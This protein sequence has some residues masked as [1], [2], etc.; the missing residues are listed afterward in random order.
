MRTNNN[1]LKDICLKTGLIALLCMAFLVRASAQVNI[2]TSIFPPYSPYYADYSGSNA[3]KVLIILQNTSSRIVKLNLK[4]SITGNNGV[5]IHTRANYVPLVP[6]TLNPHEV[7][8]L[9]GTSLK[10]VFDGSYLSVKG[11]DKGKL[12]QSSRLPEGMYQ[13]CIQAVDNADNKTLL[14]GASAGNCALLNIV[15]PDPPVLLG[16]FKTV[17]AT[18]PQAVVFNWAA[19]GAPMGTQYNIQMAEMPDINADPNHVLNATSFPML[20]QNVSGTAYLYNVLN[21]HLLAGKKYAWRVTA[22]DPMGKTV[23]KNNGVSPAS[24]FVYGGIAEDPFA[25]KIKPNDDLN[26]LTITTPDCSDARPT[27][28]LGDHSQLKI[29]WLWREQL[30]SI[31]HFGSLDTILTS[32]YTQMATA[33]GMVTIG[34][35]QLDLVRVTNNTNSKYAFSKVTYSTIAPV[36][37]FAMIAFTALAQNFVY[38]EKYTVKVTAF[39][40]DGNILGSATSCPWLLLEEKKEP[41]PPLKI[42]G[43]LTY[44][45]DKTLYHGANNTNITLQFADS[46]T[47]S[48]IDPAKPSVTI[49]T[50]PDGSFKTQMVQMPEDAAKK[51]M[52]VYINSPYYQQLDKN[53][54]INKVPTIEYTTANNQVTTTQDT[55]RLG[56]IRT[57]AYTNNLTVNIKKGFPKQLN[58]A[59][60]FSIFG[61]NPPPGKSLT[62]D[63]SSIDTMSHVPD[64]TQVILYRKQKASDIPLYEGTGTEPVKKT[65]FLGIMK[66]AD[67]YTQ[68]GATGQSIAVFKNLLCNFEQDD[69]YYIRVILPNDPAT[70]AQELTAP[71]KYYAYK[72]DT[73]YYA[74]PYTT[75]TLYNIIS[76][77][78]PMSHV[79]GKVMYQ[80]PSTPGVLH[81]YAG[82]DVTVSLQVSTN[83]GG[84]KVLD[85]CQ[86]TGAKYTINTT[87]YYGV[88]VTKDWDINQQYGNTVVGHGVTDAAGNFDIAVFTTDKM[89]AIDGVQVASVGDPCPPPPNKQKD[90]QIAKTKFDLDAANKLKDALKDPGGQVENGQDK[91]IFELNAAQDKLDFSGGL[92]GGS[93]ANKFYINDLLN[94]FKVVT[95]STDVGDAGAALQVF[96]GPSPVADEAPAPAPADDSFVERYFSLGG[97]PAVVSSGGGANNSAYHFVVQAFQTMDLGIIVTEVPELKDYPIHVS[98]KGK[99][100]K[101]SKLMLINAKV[102]VYR[103]PNAKKLKFIPDGEGALKHPVKPLINPSY[104]PDAVNYPAREWV[105]DTSIDLD[106]NQQFNV[107]KRRLMSNHTEQYMIE[108][109]PNPENSGG[110]FLP[111]KKLLVQQQSPH[112]IGVTPAPSRISGRVISS[113]TS[114]PIPKALVT[115]RLPGNVYKQVYADENG[116]FEIFNNVD[117][118]FTWVD[119]AKFTMSPYSAG[120]VQTG[121]D[122]KHTLA[123]SGNSY[124]DV[125]MLTPAKILKFTPVSETKEPVRC[126]AMTEDSTITNNFADGTFNIYLTNNVS[127][128]IRLYPEDPKYFEDTLTVAANVTDLGKVTMYKRHHR[129]KFKIVNKNNENAAVDISSFKIIINNNDDHT[130]LSTGEALKQILNYSAAYNKIYRTI[131]FDFEN[132]SVNNYTI[133]VLNTGN[134]GF[135]P[136]VF[137][138]SNE[139]SKIPRSY[140]IKMT[141]GA[142]VSGHVYFNGNPSPKARVYIDYTGQADVV[143]DAT[144]KQGGVGYSLL[145]AYTDNTGFYSIKGIPIENNTTVKLHATK[146]AVLKNATIEGSENNVALS[147]SQPA[148]S[149]FTLIRFDGPVITNVFGFPLSVEHIEKLGQ[150]NY[151]VNGIVDLSKG[152]NSPFRMIGQTDKI[153]ISNV[154]FVQQNDNWVP[155][156]SYVQLNGTASLKMKYLYSYNVKLESPNKFGQTILPLQIDKYGTGGAVKAHVSITDNSFNYPSSYLSFQGADDKPIPFYLFDPAKRAPDS[157]PI[158]PAIYTTAAENKTFHLSDAASHALAFKFIGFATTADPANSYI[159]PTNR[160]FHLDVSFKGDI[161]HSDAG[162]V[163]VHLKDLVL[164][165]NSI[166]PVKGA[167]AIV[168]D[169]QSWKLIVKDWQVDATKGGLS[170]TS[171]YISTGIVD[172][173]AG[174]F[175]LRSDLFVLDKFDVQ[176]ITLGGGLLTLKGIDTLGTHMVFDQACGS[177]H[178]PHWRFSSIGLNGKPAAIIPLPNIDTKITAADLAVNY[179][180]LVSFNNENIIGLDPV[181]KGMTLFNNSKFTFFP[182]SITS[183]IGQFAVTGTSTISVPRIS[184]APLSLLYTKSGLKDD[185]AFGSFSPVHFEGKGYVQFTSNKDAL[186]TNANHISSIKGKV[187]E[188]GKFNPINCTLSFGDTDAGTITLDQGFALNM[189]GDGD[190]K[191]EDLQLVLDNLKNPTN[192]MAVD[193]KANDWGTLKFGGLMVDPKSN[194][195][196]NGSAP[197]SSKKTAFNFEVLGDLQ[198]NTGGVSMDQIS[199]PLGKMALSYDFASHELRGSLHM[200]EIELGSYKFT[201]DIQTVMGPNGM[202]MIGAGSLNTGALLVQGFGVLNIGLMFASI[203]HLGADNI[204]TVTAYSKAKN[205]IC[206][207]N[208]NADNFKGFFLTG[209]LDILD[210]HKGFDIG[211]ASVYFNANVG[212]EASIG[213]NFAKKDYMALIGAHGSVVAG[214]NSITGTSISGSVNAHLTANATYTPKGFA[215][216]GDAAVNVGFTVSQ[217]IPIV[218]TKSITASKGAQVLF[219]VGGGQKAHMDFSLTDGGGEVNCSDIQNIP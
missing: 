68:N 46:A 91:D 95:V 104:A 101:D 71:E 10:D 127:Q 202:L 49:T 211:I 114:K 123:A 23:F 75:F 99:E 201:G 162:F 191:A 192:G 207:L 35:Y 205:N 14:S 163:N 97:I 74:K 204:N 199:T 140:I 29:A 167:D 52:R 44:G 184:D 132:V 198:V 79:K 61:V 150:N 137:N 80:W 185:M 182:S 43:R 107:G 203:D 214:L 122:A 112:E 210:E 180:Q 39:G 156:G 103:N 93:N 81:P 65:N 33:K 129:M 173:P 30:E 216:N 160:Q 144:N 86:K 153:R 88:P 15:Y 67:A 187:V 78:A 8:Q 58:D 51:F 24:Y 212:V 171:S 118:N 126:Y 174:I 50:A 120:Y 47:P 96:K 102:V 188:P 69:A 56:N 21:L 48:A 193:A 6:I 92:D 55:L 27:I 135:I 60:Y 165:G 125:L 54:S 85:N 20:S 42:Q 208:Q 11:F 142:S 124:F 117:K 177:D 32:H 196:K 63:N 45:L 213:A 37:N 169:L 161:P 90:D 5:D 121:A 22:S 215:I 154:V 84:N 138:L 176:N 197:M 16:P 59:D 3:S 134:E 26:N 34:K 148:T 105:I 115:L 219:G 28:L 194:G 7:R 209:G 133:Q 70:K 62:I 166:K 110:A 13:F 19:P 94:T 189:N 87:S 172:I 119:S 106:K 72:P 145:E 178:Q 130:G 25:K 151:V 9:N 136:Q 109:V 175:N 31:K 149:D 141:P 206:W 146:D 131:S 143:Y 159:D 12:A 139:E 218:G 168:V 155:A 36:Q 77:K 158:I 73:K 17:A 41:I 113:I 66:V 89:G 170:S 108:V 152:N 98:V 116:Y 217:Y 38:G 195:T 190:A 53:L 200:D 76:T 2:T 82:Q 157:K 179:F 1:L 83:F 40:K 186:F 100:E 4:G 128:K 64:G 111:Y 183:G 147:L 181:Q 164:D 57:L 18:N